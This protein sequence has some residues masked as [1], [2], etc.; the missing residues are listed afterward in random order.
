[1]KAEK[2]QD[3]LKL[4]LS[5]E[6]YL[7]LTEL[8]FLG[9]WV[10]NSSYGN[11]P[12][13]NPY[14][15]LEQSVFDVSRH[16]DLPKHFEHYETHS[17][18]TQRLEDRMMNVVDTYDQEA[19]WMKLASLLAQRDVHRAMESGQRFSSDVMEQVVEKELEYEQEFEENGLKNVEVKIKK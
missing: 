6:E 18:F 11:E 14:N 3:Q 1:M 12:E 17:F 7:K 8:V 9:K 19:F 16:F 13:R 15:E 4:T 2:E 10:T 5:E